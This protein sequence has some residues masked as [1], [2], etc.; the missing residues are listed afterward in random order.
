[1]SGA[2]PPH[3]D[4]SA[5][6][7]RR[8][9]LGLGRVAADE[10]DQPPVGDGE[11]GDP[12]GSDLDLDPM[13]GGAGTAAPVDDQ[14]AAFISYRPAGPAAAHRHLVHR[15]VPNGDQPAAAQF[16]RLEGRGGDRGLRLGGRG[17]RREGG[18]HQ[19]GSAH[20]LSPSLRLIR[21]GGHGSGWTGPP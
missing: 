10:L 20:R 17:N 21:S 12:G 19:D 2:E 4:R 15:G 7:H 9:Q 18:K 3:V 16:D 14:L 5:A 8:G 11:P 1:M 6:A 13:A